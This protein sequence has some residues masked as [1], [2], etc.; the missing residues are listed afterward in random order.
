MI[1]YAKC[2]YPDA[3]YP[4]DSERAKQLDSEKYYETSFIEIGGW[5]TSIGLVEHPNESF[6]SVN[7]EF[8][9]MIG[10]KYISHDIFKDWE[11]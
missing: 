5:S 2:L 4:H 10:G 8:Y 1:V 6:N 3:G 11:Q 9:I 7:F